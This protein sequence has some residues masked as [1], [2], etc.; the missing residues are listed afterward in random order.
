MRARDMEVRLTRDR[1]TKVRHTAV[2]HDTKDHDTAALMAMEPPVLVLHAILTRCPTQAPSRL[3]AVTVLL[4][5]PARLRKQSLRCRGRPQ[6]SIVYRTLR[7][8]RITT[9][10]LSNQS[11]PR[12]HSRKSRQ[13]ARLRGHLLMHLLR[14]L[15]SQPL[16]VV[17][18]HQRPR[19]MCLDGLRTP[20][21]LL[22]V[23]LSPALLLLDVAMKISKMMGSETRRQW[24]QTTA[25]AVS[26]YPSRRLHVA[27]TVGTLS[28]V[29]AVT[30]PTTLADR[31]T[32][33]ATTTRSRKLPWMPRL[34]FRKTA[35]APL[36]QSP[37][38][39]S[40][41]TTAIVL[42]GTARAITAVAQ[43]IACQT[44]MP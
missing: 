34:W 40:T 28:A 15:Q 33:T 25:S 22:L 17:L 20:L 6:R 38:A 19:L 3:P 26:I 42:I 24:C 2:A 12:E 7:C 5:S 23:S 13:S 1:S 14:S 41:A 10:R 18:K 4:T 11:R 21:G 43:S 44:T 30:A 29:I 37:L 8:L 16:D 27:T 39:V 32:A 36:D 9:L 31:N 35:S